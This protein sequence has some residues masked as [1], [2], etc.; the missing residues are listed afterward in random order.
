MQ[1]LHYI[2]M[3]QLPVKFPMWSDF[4]YHGSPFRGLQCCK[5]EKDP[6]ESPWDSL[7]Q[8]VTL[9]L[10]DIDVVEMHLLSL[11]QSS[12]DL[13]MVGLG[14][15]GCCWHSYRLERWA[16]AILLLLATVMIGHEWIMMRPKQAFWS[17]SATAQTI[18]SICPWSID[19]DEDGEKYL[20]LD[21]GIVTLMTTVT[22]MM[23]TV[24]RIAL[25]FDLVRNAEKGNLVRWSVGALWLVGQKTMLRIIK[26][27][28]L[29][30]IESFKDG[31]SGLDTARLSAAINPALSMLPPSAQVLYCT[32]LLTPFKE[33]GVGTMTILIMTTLVRSTSWYWGDVTLSASPLTQTGKSRWSMITN[34]AESVSC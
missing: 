16:V 6:P 14:D 22:V 8:S 29:R 18:S 30:I 13:T 9:R 31:G 12:N 3:W 2:P 24:L 4:L 7:Q 34:R 27:W 26:L 32:V 11:F 25:D 28:R 1:A 15:H 17:W 21:E 23:V 33:R 10:W 20:T 19:H 5:S